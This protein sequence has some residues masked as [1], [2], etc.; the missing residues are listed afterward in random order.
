MDVQAAALVAA[1]GSMKSARELV[2]A[3]WQQFDRDEIKRKITVNG[4][5]QR[6]TISRLQLL[7]RTAKHFGI[8][9]DE[10]YALIKADAQKPPAV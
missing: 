1:E 10:V 5:E 7:E 4:Q 6:V 8:S 9:L 2:D 3:Y